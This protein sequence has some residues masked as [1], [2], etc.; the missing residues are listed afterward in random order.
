[1]FQDATPFSCIFWDTL[2]TKFYETTTNLTA[3]E[4]CLCDSR[5][6]V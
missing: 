4:A 3:F 2:G 6:K 1:M 5:K